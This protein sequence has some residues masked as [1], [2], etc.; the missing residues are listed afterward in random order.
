M[1]NP[2]GVIELRKHIHDADS[3]LADLQR[4]LKEEPESAS[5]GLVVLM[6]SKGEDGNAYNIRTL[7]S[8]MRRMEVVALLEAEKYGQLRRVLG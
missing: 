2:S 8:D 6:L 7:S 1:N 4:I 5:D 3:V